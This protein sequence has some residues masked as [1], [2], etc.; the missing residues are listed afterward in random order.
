MENNT[1]TVFIHE[2]CFPN[3]L[4]NEENTNAIAARAMTEEE[5]ELLGRLWITNI[6]G[7]KGNLFDFWNLPCSSDHPYERI[8]DTGVLKTKI[9]RLSGRSVIDAI[10][11]SGIEAFDIRNLPVSDLIPFMKANAGID[12][13]FDTEGIYD[14]LKRFV[15]EDGELSE[16]VLTEPTREGR[17]GKISYEEKILP[18]YR[19]DFFIKDT[20]EVRATE[21][22]S[23]FLD[24][25]FKDITYQ[26]VLDQYEKAKKAYDSDPDRFVKAPEE[27]KRWFV[28]TAKLSK[29]GVRFMDWYRKIVEE[30]N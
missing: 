21:Y 9:D 7:G 12:G 24:I 16:L 15:S 30:G 25:R 13:M 19:D 3:E 23:R 26:E 28:V 11:S 17:E 5:T 10:L 6:M 18:E 4:F 20:G 2:V 1:T 22:R 14:L 27:P 8:A 29:D